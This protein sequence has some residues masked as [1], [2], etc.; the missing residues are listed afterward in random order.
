M[1]QTPGTGTPL[2]PASYYPPNFFPVATFGISHSAILGFQDLPTPV[3]E[4]HTLLPINHELPD[5]SELFQVE[6]WRQ[7]PD[8]HASVG[9]LHLPLS[10]LLFHRDSVALEG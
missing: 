1:E 8:P 2:S 7:L 3:F 6:A 10:G 5:L 9:L 4:L